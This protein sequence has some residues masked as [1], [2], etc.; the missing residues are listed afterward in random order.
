MCFVDMCTFVNLVFYFCY[1]ELLQI[2]K[3]YANNSIGT[4]E[5]ESDHNTEILWSLFLLL[6]ACIDT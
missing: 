3:A 5:R 1:Q 6:L 2:R 4:T